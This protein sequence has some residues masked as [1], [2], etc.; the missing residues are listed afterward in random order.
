VPKKKIGLNPGITVA[1]TSGSPSL[2][3]LPSPSPLYMSEATKTETFSEKHGTPCR[4]RYP[5]SQS[6]FFQEDDRLGLLEGLMEG[7]VLEDQFQ[8][9]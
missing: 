3:S 1:L 6:K 2:G 9:L 8:H 4:N 5:K 7:S